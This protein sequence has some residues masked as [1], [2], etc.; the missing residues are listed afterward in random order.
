MF[1]LD[2]R[3]HAHHSC[4]TSPPKDNKHPHLRYITFFNQHYNRQQHSIN[5]YCDSMPLGWGVLTV[6]KSGYHVLLLRACHSIFPQFLVPI[7][8]CTIPFRGSGG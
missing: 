8:Y 1:H 3:A 7:F 5:G 6:M 2:S 4:D